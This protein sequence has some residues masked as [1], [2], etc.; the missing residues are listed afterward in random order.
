MLQSTARDLNCNSSTLRS[1]V[2]VPILTEFVTTA[3]IIL[4]MY[5]YT[6]LTSAN[7]YIRVFLDSL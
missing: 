1:G 3:S 7:Y 6:Y 4:Y 5:A 2:H